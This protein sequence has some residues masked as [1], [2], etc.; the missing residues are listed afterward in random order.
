MEN[1]GK[2]K[3]FEELVVWQKSHEFVL[4][5]YKITKNFPK[6][7]NFVLTSQ[8]KR[9]AISISANI[10]E[11]YKKHGTKDKVR[12]FNISQ[13]SLEECRYYLILARDIEY[14]TLQE[15]EMLKNLL[16]STS[17]M[18]NAY[19]KTIQENM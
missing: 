19:S 18:L 13:G 6:E 2:T 8:L 5:I 3:S 7:E 9:A 16:G 1:K 14:I 17:Y 10:A 12:F 4:S 11:G 15:Y